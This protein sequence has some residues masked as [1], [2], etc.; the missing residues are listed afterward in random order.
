MPEDRE[1][2]TVFT[3]EY[4]QYIGSYRSVL[5]SIGRKRGPVDKPV[6]ILSLLFVYSSNIQYTVHHTTPGTFEYFVVINRPAFFSFI[7]PQ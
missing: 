5:F 6:N 4:I 3:A 1:L 2:S 7:R